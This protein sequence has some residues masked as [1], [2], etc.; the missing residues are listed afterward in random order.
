MPHA[1]RPPA[2]F[3]SG[4]VTTLDDIFLRAQ[5]QLDRV[6]RRLQLGKPPVSGRPRFLVIQ[7]DGLSRSALEKALK[8]GRMP[9]LRR[10]MR[11]TGHRLVPMSVGIPTS[12]PAFQLAVMYGAEPDIPGFH[13]HDKLRHTDIH[14]PRA[15]HAAF[16]ESAQAGERRGILRAGSVYGCVFTGSA[17][18][19]FFSFAR[20]TRP[21]APG[22]VR[23]VSA[24][25]VVVWVAL[26][27]LTL[28]GE[29]TFRALG[30]V[31]RR[32]RHRKSEWKWLKKKVAISVWTR[33]W[34]TCSVARDVYDGVPAIYVNY[35]D[36]DEAAHAFGPRSHQAFSALRGIDSSLRQLWRV[37]RRVPG[38][39]YD[40]YILSDHGQVS[41]TPFHSVAGGRRFEHAFFDLLTGQLE[42]STRVSVDRPRGTFAEV[43][44][45]SAAA[46][47]AREPGPPELSFEPYLDVRESF[48]Q[49]GIRV[50]S[51]G[52][53]AFI[54]FLD[55]LEPLLLEEIEARRPGLTAIL[56][57]SPGVGFVLV[58]SADG[59]VCF[60]RGEAHS[61]DDPTGPFASREDR[62]LVTQGLAALMS[63]RSAGDLVVYGIGAPE[64]HVSYIDE[65]G[66]HAGPS[67]DE[68]HTFLLAP[69]AAELPGSIEHPRQ[70]YDMLA[71]YGMADQ[72]VESVER[73]RL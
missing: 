12:T 54:Y 47:S 26:K 2:P 66:G 32:P 43:G 6:V 38:H 71:R 17:E 61:L 65:V 22:L 13:Y 19:D 68:L 10:F 44:A 40:V 55:A 16:V 56:S 52:P 67:P 31:I 8:R 63:M 49:D 24:C 21:R 27:S 14:F 48:E 30:R 73:G 1:H 58:R 9:F 28:T 60:W 72:A 18:H 41:C 4:A 35:I 70:L 20:L 46:R 62:A 15:G 57:K 42:V 51:S 37:L 3:S 5:H 36:Y 39:R 64:G 50:V 53:N 23:V 25:V 33:E 7:I 45:V 59:P 11:R 29:E 34:F 69:A